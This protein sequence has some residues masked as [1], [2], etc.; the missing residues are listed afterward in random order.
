MLARRRNDAGAV[1]P[2][3]ASGS[4]LPLQPQPQHHRRKTPG[5][6]CCLP[7]AGC[8]V[9]GLSVRCCALTSDFQWHAG[10]LFSSTFLAMPGFGHLAIRCLSLTFQLSTHRMPW[11]S[12]SAN[13]AD[14]KPYH[15]TR[16]SGTKRRSPTCAQPSRHATSSSR[17][18]TPVSTPHTSPGSPSHV[19]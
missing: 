9:I 17:T 11:P 6:C 7:R 18:C 2:V 14:A 10:C 15:R 12:P 19:R 16:R 5:L 1:H 3:D 4:V 8:G 13:T